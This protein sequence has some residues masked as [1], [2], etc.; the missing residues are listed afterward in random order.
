MTLEKSQMLY[1]RGIKA[2]VIAC[3]TAT[4]AAIGLLREHFTTIPVIGIEPAVKPATLVK[5]HPS[6]LV[7]ATPTTV[8][9][10]K[11]LELAS[12][13]EDK[14][15]ILPLSC[16]GLMEFV[17]QGELESRDLETYLKNLLS[18]VLEKQMIDVV[19]L[20]CTHYPFVRESI[21]AVLH[22]LENGRDVPVIDGSLG[23]ARELRR[24]LENQELLREDGHVGEV[25]LECS[26]P[27]KEE[28]MRLLF[29]A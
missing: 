6:V 18:S 24:R 26:L 28:L 17:E 1:D 7:L 9:G 22:Q 21:K 14:A 12:R 25:R 19:V 15:S 10:D 4:S 2:L 11:F 13:F 27:E 23:T 20:G 3:N 16:P 29:E 5:D 8:H